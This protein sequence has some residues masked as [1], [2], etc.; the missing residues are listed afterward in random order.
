MAKD[1][2]GVSQKPGANVIESELIA[3]DSEEHT[4]PWLWT[5]SNGVKLKWIRYLSEV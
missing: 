5:V 2:S 4:D 1:C 3:E